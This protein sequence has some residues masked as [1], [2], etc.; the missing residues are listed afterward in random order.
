MILDSDQND[1]KDGTGVTNVRYLE[2]KV[3]RTNQLIGYSL[4]DTSLMV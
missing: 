2:S 3:R 4:L 1:Y